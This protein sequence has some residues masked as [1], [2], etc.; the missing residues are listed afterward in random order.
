MESKSC[1][2][3]SYT[4]RRGARRMGVVAR[5]SGFQRWRRDCRGKTRTVTMDVGGGVEDYVLEAKKAEDP[6][7]QWIVHM[8]IEINFKKR[9][10]ERREKESREPGGM[11]TVSALTT[12]RPGPF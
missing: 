8:N 3:R 11:R 7:G 10:R 12:G 9:E 4:Q 5:E 6:R 1:W 2:S